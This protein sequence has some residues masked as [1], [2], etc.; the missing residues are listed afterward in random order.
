MYA[1]RSY[2]GERRV[3]RRFED[4]RVSRD[5]RRRRHPGEDRQREV[6]R[7]DHDADAEREVYQLVLL[8]RELDGG[9]HLRVPEHL[10]C[11]KFQEIDR[12]GDVTVGFR[13]CFAHLHDFHG[14]ELEAPFTHRNN[15]V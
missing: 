2:Y 6:P 11:V 4:H 15:F 12:L 1:I 8:S 14:V 5:H 10:T 9:F 7:G 3:A 13:P